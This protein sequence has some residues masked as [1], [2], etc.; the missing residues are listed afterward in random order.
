M[1]EQVAQ[2]IID[3][4]AT[5]D[6]EPEPDQVSTEAGHWYLPDGTPFYTVKRK[7]G[8][9][10]GQERPVSLR[11]DRKLMTSLGV[12][13]SVTTVTKVIDKPGLNQFLLREMFNAVLELE[14][15][16][17]DDKD[18]LFKRALERTHR[19]GREASERGNKL[20]GAIERYLLT[21][22]HGVAM[23]WIEH[24]QKILDTLE[25][26]GIYLDDGHVATLIGTDALG[27]QFA[28]IRESHGDL[29]STVDDMTVG[30]D[31]PFTR[32]DHNAGAARP[33]QMISRN[34]TRT[35]RAGRP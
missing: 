24:V 8:P 33:Y 22:Y 14:W 18:A 5:K 27:L 7:S 20:H 9:K 2:N 12:V 3:F 32:V 6:S 34:V 31:E 23:E 35:G 10:R 17:G 11:W 16:D 29:V 26:Y 19:R 4:A 21:G 1:D 28:P 13:P 15:N 25:Q 30:E